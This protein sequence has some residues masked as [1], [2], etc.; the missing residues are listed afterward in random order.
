M[1]MVSSLR[2]K[3]TIPHGEHTSSPRPPLPHVQSLVPSVDG[4]RRRME[5]ARSRR[6]GGAIL[7]RYIIE[8]LTS[9]HPGDR[10]SRVTSCWRRCTW[11][12]VG[13]R[14]PTALASFAPLATVKNHVPALVG[15]YV[16]EIAISL[17]GA[18]HDEEKLCHERLCST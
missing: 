4:I 14:R 1:R 8:R 5:S 6:P 16:L 15:E 10:S 3:W 13:R 12:L 2:E 9:A 7:D 18:R 11:R 17:R